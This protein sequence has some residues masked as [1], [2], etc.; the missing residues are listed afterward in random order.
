MIPER[1]KDELLALRR[2]Y[3][4]KSLSVA[5][6]DP[7]KIVR[8][9]G[10]YLYAE[11]GQRYLDCVNNVSH[12]GHAHPHVVAA[13]QQ[14]MAL[15]NTNTRYLHDN[16]VEYALRLTATLPPQLSVCFFVNSGSEA[17]DLALR[18][19]RAYTGQQDM[20]VLD[21]AYHGNL[22][23]LIDLSP[24]KFDGPGGN[25]KP[26][27]T[28]VAPL[29]DPYRGQFRS[30]GVQAGRRYAAELGRIIAG[31]L[32][33]RGRGFAGFLAESIAGC[34]G[35]VSYPQGYLQAA[36]EQVR[37]EGGLCLLDEVQVGFGRIG[38][39]FWAFQA[40]DVV[41]DIVTMGKPIGN[42][43]PLAAVVTTPVIAE[44]FANGMEY[45]NTFG[46]NPVSSAIGLAVL[47][48][49]EREGLQQ[50]A[51]ATG[52]HLLK[53]LRELQKRHALIGDVRGSG[54]FL[55]VELVRDRSTL[56]P[57]DAEADQVIQHL[58]ARNILVSTDGPFGNVL[59]LKPPM[60]FTRADADELVTRLDEVLA[61]LPPGGVYTRA[62]APG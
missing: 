7:L 15:L 3:L 38:T 31:N 35:Q 26:E 30:A 25:G 9:Q 47:D 60:V 20:I 24:Y 16:V 53:G 45:F 55:G 59:K 51:L 11:D 21:H 48:V 14:Q 44:S 54:L 58:R 50:H 28:H 61:D 52:K 36:F 12:V 6:H 5:Y 40:Q 29:P 37:G 42:G 43:H 1:S 10:Q 46:G 18:L 23:S 62:G 57:A 34:G 39:H 41:P 4:G 19:A 27:H 33:F 17:N 8:G 22:Q 2:E 56:E 13:G 49:I 32:A